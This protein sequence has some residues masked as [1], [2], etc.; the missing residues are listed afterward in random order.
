MEYDEL[1]YAC[2]I[3]RIFNYSCDKARL[4]VSRFPLPGDV[5]KLNRRELA[6]IFGENSHFVN[7]ILNPIFLEFG[8]KDVDWAHSH[9]VRLYYIGDSDYPG[10][11]RECADA[12]VVLYFKGNCDLNHKRMIS[13]VGSRR[14]TPYGRKMCSDLVE[15]LAELEEPPIIVSGLAY[16]IDIEA[17]QTALRCGLQTVGVMATG[18]DAIYPAYHRKV[19]VQMVSQGGLVTDFPIKTPPVPLNFVRRNRI[20]A[21]LCDATVL[22]ESRVDGGGVITSKM[23]SSYDREVFALPG[24]AVDELSQ[25]CNILIKESCAEMIIG[26]DSLRSSLGWKNLS[27]DRHMMAKFLTFESDNAVKRD[28][29][30]HLYQGSLATVDDLM[31][32]TGA[33]RKDIM[34][35]LTELELEGRISSDLLGRFLLVK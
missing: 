6:G 16:G 10:R 30:A 7:D 8:Q 25:G 28:I 12:P 34:M 15:S 17:H 19:A 32:K 24:R 13:F 23:A 18:L 5:F 33:G 22:V 29:V 11:L 21:G 4:L 14:A 35:N 26:R 1:V 9:G 27:K 2:A 3:N 20:I 31:E